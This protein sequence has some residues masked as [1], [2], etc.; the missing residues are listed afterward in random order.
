MKEIDNIFGLRTAVATVF[1]D[2]CEGNY[3]NQSKST[4]EIE[5]KENKYLGKLCKRNH[6]YNNT[7]KSIRYVLKNHCVECLKYLEKQKSPSRILVKCIICSKEYYINKKHLKR[8]NRPTTCSRKCMGIWQ[9]KNL[10]GKKAYNYKNALR[11]GICEICKKEFTTYSK[12][13]RFCSIEC[14]DIGHRKQINKICF[15]C[16]KTYTISKSTDK[17]NKIRKRKLNFCSLKCGN[18]YYSGKNHPKWIED[19]SKLKDRNRTIRWSKDMKIWRKKIY[20][21]DNYTCQMC[22][23]KSS[24]NNSVILNAHHIKTFN[25][26]P[27]LILDIN[28]GITLCEKCHKKTYEKEK[29][30]EKYLYLKIQNIMK[31]YIVGKC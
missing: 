18:D 25:D 22:N 17:W 11:H 30:F 8:S 26:F 31:K 15:Y 24:A 10:R 19:R 2:L 1:P 20:E 4:E 6:N 29:D 5:M 7:G 14:K 16:G 9:S 13:Q 21:R 3:S 27:E 12:K 28:N 23:N